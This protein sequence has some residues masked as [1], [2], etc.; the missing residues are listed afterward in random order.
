MRIVAHAK[1][2]WVLDITGERDD[3]YHLMDMLMQPITLADTVRLTDADAISLTIS[4]NPDL[5]CDAS[6]LAWRAAELL[7]P[8]ADRPRGVDIVLEKVI[9]SGAG[10]GGGSTDAAAVL[11]G[12]NHLWGLSLPMETLE[13]LALSL[14]AD[15][16]FFLSSGLCRGQG[17][18]EAVRPLSRGPKWPL[19]IIQP[20]SGLSTKEIFTAYAASDQA[21]HPDIDSMEQIL[22]SEDLS[23][24]PI[25]P[26]NVLEQVSCA[27]RSEIGQAAGFLVRN[28]AIC[29]QMSGSGSAVFG[30]F[31]NSRAA[32]AAAVAAKERWEKVF[33]CT[34]CDEALQMHG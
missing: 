18:G 17:I 7:Q 8:Y 15:V 14:G 24:L 5:P 1:I 22:L 3:G 25:H 23:I 16:P 19:V 20:C 10:L 9:P 31:E 4:G 28:G 21:I 34:T 26:G 27:A 2:N 12:L 30:V 11:L 29:A 33:V 13:N 32:D 6:N